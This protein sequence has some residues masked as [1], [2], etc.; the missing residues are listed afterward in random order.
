M[1]WIAG[2]FV[3]YAITFIITLSRIAEPFREWWG[4]GWW[5]FDAEFIQCAMCVG[6][7]VAAATCLWHMSLWD[8][9]AAYGLSYFLRT[10][11]RN[12]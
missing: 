2:G 3:V 10:L 12:D 1:D 6:V 4:D 8:T 7:W 9:V 11:E 5:K